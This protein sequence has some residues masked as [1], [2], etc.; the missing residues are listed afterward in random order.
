TS[1]ADSVLVN[2]SPPLSVVTSPNDTICSGDDAILTAIAAG[3]MGAP[4]TYTWTDIAGNPVNTGTPI[5]VTPGADGTQYIVTVTDGCESPPASDTVTIFYY[6][7]PQPSF[8]SDIVDG[9]YPIDVLFTNTTPAG[10]SANCSWVFGNGDTD[11]TCNPG[12]VSY[13][14]PGAYDVTLTV[15]SPEGCVS[16]TTEVAYINVYDY[17][18]AGFIFGHSLQMF[19]TLK[20]LLQINHHQTLPFTIGNLEPMVF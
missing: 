7:N 19:W 12:L 2:I 18:T 10:T 15:T 16:D 1:P 8:T 4:Y 17:P 5:T 3:G 6:P 11:N 14:I 13:L 9:C 20:L